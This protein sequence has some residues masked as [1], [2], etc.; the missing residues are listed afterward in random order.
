LAGGVTVGAAA[1]VDRSVVCDGARIAGGAEVT[2]WVGGSGAMIG[3]GAVLNGW[4]RR[5][6]PYQDHARGWPGV[7]PASSSAH[8]Q[9]AGSVWARCQRIDWIS[10]PDA[11][12]RSRFAGRSTADRTTSGQKIVEEINADPR[13]SAAS[14]ACTAAPSAVGTGP[15]IAVD[16]AA[17]DVLRSTGRSRHFH[18]W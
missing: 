10:D 14:S 17:A 2:R 15:G 9:P 18:A 12:Q 7:G 13:P 11:A 5:A 8:Q 6:W 1:S 16:Q 4:R 3:N